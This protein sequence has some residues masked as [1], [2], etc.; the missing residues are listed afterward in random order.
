[1]ADLLEAG[2]SPP[3]TLKVAGYLTNRNRL[4][5][6]VWR[7]AD[8]LQLNPRAAMHLEPPRRMA[9]IYYAV[10]A[11]LPTQSRIRLLREITEA[12][13]DSARN[14]LSWTRGLIE[15]IA[16]LLVGGLVGIVVLSLFF[17]LFNLISALS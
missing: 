11:E 10:R 5:N 7:L 8:Q 6:A 1:M 17:P 4:R 13:S 2:L 15:P 9:T 3:D 12:Y 16:I 14:R